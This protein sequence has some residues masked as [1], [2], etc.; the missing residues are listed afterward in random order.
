[1]VGNQA[2]SENIEK[3]PGAGVDDG[4]DKGV[5]VSGLVKDGLSTIATVQDVVP[6]AADGRPGSSWHPTVL[7]QA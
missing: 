7:M 2:V 1:M 3:E 6:H 4:L 5:S